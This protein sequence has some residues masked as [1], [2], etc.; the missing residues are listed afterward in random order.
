[1]VDISALIPFTLSIGGAVGLL[2]NVIIIF[3]AIVIAD[4]VIAHEIEAKKSLIMAFVAYLIVPLILGAI[5]SAGLSIPYIIYIIP[6]VVWVALSELLLKAE[7]KKKLIVAVVAFIIFTAL[8]LV[9][10]P[11]MISGALPV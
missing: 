4:K 2:V 7:M 5:I 3:I 8:N 10:V 11:M 1:M 9:G 6:L